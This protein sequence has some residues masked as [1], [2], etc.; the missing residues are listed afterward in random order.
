MI[1]LRAVAGNLVNA[2]RRHHRAAKGR[3]KDGQKVGRLQISEY[4][5]HPGYFLMYCDR[6][7]K[8]ITDT[9][10]DT[11]EAAKHQAEVEY[12]GVSSTWQYLQESQ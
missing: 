7:W 1:W 5:A 10:H 9:C 11:V 4:D 2:V 6:E 12:E 3:R 8:M